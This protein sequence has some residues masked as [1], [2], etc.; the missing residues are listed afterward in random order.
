MESMVTVIS[1][2]H[3]WRAAANE[4]GKSWQERVQALGHIPLLERAV[5]GQWAAML[6]TL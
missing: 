6:A 1:E 2:S 5:Q 3:A 4:L